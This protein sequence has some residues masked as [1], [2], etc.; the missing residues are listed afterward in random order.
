MKTLLFAAAT[1]ALVAGTALAPAMAALP[2]SAAAANAPHYVWE[3]GYNRH[4]RIYGHWVSVSP[5]AFDVSGYRGFH[6]P[7]N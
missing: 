1:L 4:G 6:T 2:G 7:T 5:N 3:Q